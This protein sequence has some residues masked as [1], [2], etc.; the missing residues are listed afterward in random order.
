[1]ASS[2]RRGPK[3]GSTV[4]KIS[5][6]GLGKLGLCLAATLANSG[7]SVIGVDIDRERVARIARGESPI[8]ERGLLPLLDATK[9]S[10]SVTTDCE[11]AVCKTDATFVVVPTPSTKTGEF[12]LK[13]VRAAMRAIGKALATKEG[14]HLVV[15]SS[16][17]MPGS[18]DGAVRQT[19][20]ETSG[21]RIC[22]DFGLCY[23]PEFIALGDVIRG[24]RNPDFVLVGES[25]VHA[26]DLLSRIQKRVCSNSPPIER[27]SFWNAELAK[28]AL[29]SFVTMKMSFA[30]TL[31]EMCERMPGGEVD[32]ITHAISRDRRIGAANLKGGVG[33]GGPCFP[34]DN[35]AFARFAK[36]IGV[37]A[38]LP[39]ATD[40]TN[41]RQ[42]QRIV[43][44][45]GD[46]FSPDTTRI[47]VF[48][49]TYKPNTD[50]TEASQ[51]LMVAKGLA[52]RGFEVHGFDPALLSDR[53][54][55]SSDIKLE[56]T[57]D[58]CLDKSD[59][60]IIAT[61]WEPIS[62]MSKARLSKKIVLDCWRVLNGNR[63]KEPAN[64]L[65]LGQD[66]I[67]KKPSALA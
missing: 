2:L 49:L 35:I 48:G 32:T 63:P 19:L 4:R 24:L 17:V 6:V 55:S 36:K 65:A 27:M 22:R 61:P 51:S 60:C 46:R 38:D 11:E 10:F 20:E 15:L 21:K 13:F 31:A 56:S 18:M 25:D 12:S 29:N 28:M 9:E 57:A 40:K 5:V 53:D 16:T 30:N 66:M 14:Y 1:M 43:D 26:G 34:R 44:L 42:A 23:N 54:I 37:K 58:A 8:Y 45:I 50:V 41:K 7:F 39:R 47:G 64:Y 59:V 52:I 67:S 62:T 33:Y 3:S